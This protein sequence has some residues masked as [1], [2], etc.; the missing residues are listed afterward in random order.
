MKRA[1]MK[2]SRM[3]RAGTAM[4][5]HQRG[6]TLIELMIVVAIIGILAA[7][8]IPNYQKYVE[9]SRRSEG[10]ALLQSAMARQESYYGQYLKYASDVGALFNGGTLKNDDYHVA[11]CG[12]QQGCDGKAY[13]TGQYVRM[14]ATPISSGAQQND[15]VLWLDSEGNSGRIY[16]GAEMGKW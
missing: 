4:K 9:R 8:A 14:T 3:K 6:F 1:E 2:Q 11:V 5:T 15:G 16:D 12:T 10:Q 7:I 13:S